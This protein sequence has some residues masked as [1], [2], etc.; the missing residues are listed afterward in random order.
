MIY[1]T[2]PQIILTLLPEGN[3]ERSFTDST[4][5][6]CY[7]TVTVFARLVGTF[8]VS[9]PVPGYSSGDPRLPPCLAAASHASHASLVRKACMELSRVSGV[10][11][12][13]EPYLYA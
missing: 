8:T 1:G 13:P 11:G 7:S 4:G 5:P 3:V 9:L 10:M 2:V 12:A 6:Q